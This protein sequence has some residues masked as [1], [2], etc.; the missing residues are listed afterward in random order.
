MRLRVNSIYLL[1]FAVLFL[2]FLKLFPT[3]SDETFYFN[4]AKQ[5][6]DGK[7]LYKDFFFAHPPLQTFSLFLF[8]KILGISYFAAKLLPVLSSTACLFLVYL[9]A[10]EENNKS[11]F[12]STLIL[13]FTPAFLSYQAIGYGVWLAALLVLISYYCLLRRKTFLSTFTLVLAF[14]TRY[15]AILYVPYLFYK[16][17][18]KKKFLISAFLFMI[19]GFSFM[20]LLFGFDFITDTVFF[21]FSKFG[22]RDFSF[23]KDYVSLNLFLLIPLFL[24]KRDKSFLLVLFADLLVMILFKAP[25]YHYFLISIPFYAVLLSEMK[26]RKTVIICILFGLFINLSTINYYNAPNSL[27]SESDS[28]FVNNSIVF[29]E[30]IVTNYL[31]FANKARILDDV[32][33]SFP[34]HLESE[35]IVFSN[36]PDFIINGED[37]YYNSFFNE[38]Y[39]VFSVD[40][41]PPVS[42]Y[43]V[44][45]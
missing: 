12:L 44:R 18:N 19:I 10:K 37:Y 38:T 40:S 11:S 20:F 32:F 28:F 4:I 14:F 33:D 23:I 43:E 9:I 39:P 16:S 25:F 41:T 3:Y 29:G 7:V 35:Q 6:Y 34:Q 42:V 24:F 26:D 2:S 17:H 5:V 45:R 27:F 21:H 22:E 36:S 1:V 30:P 15:L 13:L 8:F 31:S